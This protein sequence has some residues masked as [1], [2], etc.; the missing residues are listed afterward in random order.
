MNSEAKDGPKAG[1]PSWTSILALLVFQLT[2]VVT[3][4][5]RQPTQKPFPGYTHLD[6]DGLKNITETTSQ[7][8]K[9]RSTLV[10]FH[11]SHSKVGGKTV[12]LIKSLPKM[13]KR[14]KLT[15][16]L[17]MFDCNQSPEECGRLG[18]ENYPTISLFFH[19]NKV[20]YQGKKSFRDLKKWIHQKMTVFALEVDNIEQLNHKIELVTKL[21]KST[22]KRDALV[23]FC[24]ILQHE[25]FTGFNGI[26]RQ[27]E[28][29]ETY[30]YTSSPQV[31]KQLNCSSG[32]ILF[33]GRRGW[34]K[35]EQTSRKAYGLERFILKQKYYHVGFLNFYNYARFC[36]PGTQML[37]LIDKDMKEPHYKLLQ[38]L[39]LKMPASSSNMSFY[40]VSNEIREGMS[41]RMIKRVDSLLGI[42]GDADKPALRFVKMKGDQ[43]EKYKFTDKLEL[44]S[45]TGWLQRV[46]EGKES[47]YLKSQ[48]VKRHHRAFKR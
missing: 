12:T 27:R 44:K 28:F 19:R 35:Y 23:V 1:K 22:N 36:Q 34:A 11:S 46:V 6:L 18:V 16:Q 9:N 45:V 29:D 24:G 2:V 38:D 25:A 4:K 47:P 8:S 5:E 42:N 7:F 14:H 30:I 3:K 10:V 26:S 13:L 31:W 41:R 17:R 48:P 32:D 43:L 37:V 40:F 39:A 15:L 33:L 20:E 21:S